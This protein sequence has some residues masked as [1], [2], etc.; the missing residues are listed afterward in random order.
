MTSFG[1]GTQMARQ[2][3]VRSVVALLVL[4]VGAG[5]ALAW[6]FSQPD[7]HPFMF[8]LGLSWVMAC[9]GGAACQVFSR[10]DPKYF[11]PARWERNGKVYEW[12][13]VRVFRRI[14]LH[15]PL[16]WL[17]PLG[18]RSGRSGLDHLL[19]DI[20]SAEGRHAVAAGV[21]L[22]VA[23]VYA[24]T[25]HKAIAAWLVL[26]TVPLNVYPVALQRWNRGRVLEL[27]RR[28]A[29]VTRPDREPARDLVHGRV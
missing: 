13:G 23:A 17:G 25:D 24:M 21:S 16:G 10:L 29:A 14:L 27:Q 8:A 12:I 19:R 9:A 15:T 4:S 3:P 20:D 28:V 2:T 5:C 11:R 6:T 18:L 1:H 22:T 7:R 26:V